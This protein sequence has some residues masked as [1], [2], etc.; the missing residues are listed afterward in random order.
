MWNRQNRVSRL[1]LPYL[2]AGMVG[3]LAIHKL[4]E[5]IMAI[6]TERTTTTTTR[7]NPTVEIR[8]TNDAASS[9][10]VVLG[11]IVALAAAYFLYDYYATPNNDQTLS[12]MA[13]TTAPVD[14]TTTN[15]APAAQA[16]PANQQ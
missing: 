16:A 3:A 5:M 9:L 7:G 8:E 15:M 6:T 13:S 11:I 10:L 14:Q 2:A 1:S 4:K 12:P